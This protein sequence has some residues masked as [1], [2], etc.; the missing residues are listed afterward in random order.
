VRTLGKVIYWLAVLAISVALLIALVLFFE[1]RD[2]S[3]IEGAQPV[4]LA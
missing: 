3:Q 2:D 4:L 1:S